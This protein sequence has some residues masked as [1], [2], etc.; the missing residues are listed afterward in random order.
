MDVERALKLKDGDTVYV[1][2]KG[3]PGQYGHLQERG[4]VRGLPGPT[5]HTN[6]NGI[7]YI[8]INIYLPSKKH[9]TIFPSHC[10]S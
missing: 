8:S 9:T 6:I 5:V 10:L 2:Y 7:K 4:S 1:N 3:T